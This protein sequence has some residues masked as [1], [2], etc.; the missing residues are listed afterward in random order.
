MT[1]EK[2]NYGRTADGVLITDQLIEE[3]VA[4]AEAGY[5]VDDILAERNGWTQVYPPRSTDSERPSPPGRT[6]G[7]AA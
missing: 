1:M 3:M 5:D 7:R 2:K 4:E 6:P